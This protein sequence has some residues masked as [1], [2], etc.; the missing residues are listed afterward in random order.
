[1]FHTMATVLLGEF[2]RQKKGG[3]KGG[4]ARA[5]TSVVQPSD[6]VKPR[7]GPGP[8]KTVPSLGKNTLPFARL[9]PRANAIS[10]DHNF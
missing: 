9:W 8:S 7:G 10:D 1:M 4:K 6:P 5:V 2:K 3:K